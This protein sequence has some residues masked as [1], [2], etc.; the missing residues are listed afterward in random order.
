MSPSV[1][2]KITGSDKWYNKPL[3]QFIIRVIVMVLV[4][5]LWQILINWLLENSGMPRGFISVVM[6]SILVIIFGA[7]FLL[8]ARFWFFPYFTAAL[9]VVTVYDFLFKTQF[10]AFVDLGILILSVIWIVFCIQRRR[11]K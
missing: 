6:N 11:K 9:A 8:S 3:N 4:V 10:T 2:D 1:S 5:V 7:L